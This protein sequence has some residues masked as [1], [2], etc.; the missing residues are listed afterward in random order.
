ME[1]LRLNGRGAQDHS[2]LLTVVEQL[3]N[4]RVGADD[5]PAPASEGETA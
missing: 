5:A 4:H 3:S 2:A 1:S